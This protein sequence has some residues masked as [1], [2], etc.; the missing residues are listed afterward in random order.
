MKSIKKYQDFKINEK[1]DDEDEYP[2]D[3]IY[4][5]KEQGEE[6]VDFDG[7]MDY[8][9]QTIESLFD[10]SNIN[11]NVTNQDL[12]LTVFVFPEKKE[13]LKNLTKIF[14]I[15]NKLRRDI[16]PQYSSEFEIYKQKDGYTVITFQFTYEEEGTSSK[17]PWKER[18][19]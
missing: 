18:T 4:D 10:N 9:C 11:C 1:W 19:F 15:A 3:D 17:V 2:N 13:T 6:E 14:D 7:E 12:D 16:L 8:L 5:E